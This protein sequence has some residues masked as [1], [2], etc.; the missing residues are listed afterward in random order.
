[1]MATSIDPSYM[2][3]ATDGHGELAEYKLT[4]DPAGTVEPATLANPS[5]YVIVEVAIRPR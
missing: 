2:A 3:G 5:D 4:S 1:M